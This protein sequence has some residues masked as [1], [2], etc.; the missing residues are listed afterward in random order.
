MLNFGCTKIGGPNEILGKPLKIFCE[1]GLRCF[2]G[3]C[4]IVASLIFLKPLNTQ[5]N[6]NKTYK[7]K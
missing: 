6:Q 5:K 4:F 1:P 7:I 3:M 2:A